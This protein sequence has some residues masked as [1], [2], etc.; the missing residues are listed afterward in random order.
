MAEEFFKKM[1]PE[2]R[3]DALFSRPW[4]RAFRKEFVVVLVGTNL[5]H[6]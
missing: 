2:S 5:L 6:H 3:L 4:K 1:P